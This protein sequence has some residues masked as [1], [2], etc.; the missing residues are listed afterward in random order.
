[1]RY[2]DRS[3]MSWRPFRCAAWPLGLATTH[4]GS[5]GVGFREAL[6]YFSSEVLPSQATTRLSFEPKSKL[7]RWLFGAK[8]HNSNVWN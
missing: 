3:G 2:W 4:G 8:R 7:Q 5:I 1:M 6:T